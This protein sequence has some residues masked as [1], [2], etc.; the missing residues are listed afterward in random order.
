MVLKDGY[1]RIGCRLV[2]EPLPR[3]CETLDSTSS[4][5]E[6]WANKQEPSR[7]FENLLVFLN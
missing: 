2:V 1:F 6:I 5:T 3:L 7:I 4:T